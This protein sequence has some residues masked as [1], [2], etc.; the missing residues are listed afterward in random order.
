MVSKCMTCNLS[1]EGC[2]DLRIFTHCVVNF[3]HILTRTERYDFFK[4]VLFVLLLDE[5]TVP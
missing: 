4:H 3:T 5:G 2:Y 1:E